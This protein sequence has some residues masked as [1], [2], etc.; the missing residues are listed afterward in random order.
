MWI[1]ENYTD[2]QH[3]FNLAVREVKRLAAESILELLSNIFNKTYLCL[4]KYML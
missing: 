2:L 1:V 4:L 3:Y